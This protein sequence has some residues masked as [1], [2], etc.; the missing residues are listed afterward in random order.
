M[1]EDTGLQLINRAIFTLKARHLTLVEESI[2][3]GTWQGK[4][5]AQMAAQCQY[6]L[7]YLMRDIGPKFWKLLSEAFGEEVAKTNLRVVLERRYLNGTEPLRTTPQVKE[8]KAEIAVRPTQIRIQGGKGTKTQPSKDWGS[9]SEVSVVYGRT[10]ELSKLKQWT[11]TDGCRLIMVRGMSGT[12]KTALLRKLV[13]DIEDEYDHII[14]RNLSYS[15]TP[16]ELVNDLLE[17]LYY[18]VYRYKRDRLSQLI[19]YLRSLRCLLILDGAETIMA[20]GQLAGRYRR[21]YTDYGELLRRL[22]EES[23]KSCV[24]ISS[25]ENIREVDWKTAENGL[26][27]SLMLSGLKETEARELFAEVGLI[28]E[29]NLSALS[30]RYQGNPAALK[31]VAKLIQEVFNSNVAEFLERNIFVFGDIEELVASSFHRLSVLEKEVS[32]CLAIWGDSVSLDTLEK[33]ITFPMSTKKLL[34]VLVSLRG[35]SLLETHTE[36][37]LSRFALKPMMCEYITKQLVENICGT[38]AIEEAQR[39]QWNKTEDE[40]IELTLSTTRGPVNLSQWLQN[41]FELGWEPLSLLYDTKPDC[42]ALMLRRTFHLRSQQ[43]KK[44][45]KQIR[46]ET[47]NQEREL[48]LLVATRKADPEANAFVQTKQK[49]RIRVQLQPAGE[50]T[51]LPAN[52]KLS[53]LNQSKKTLLSV[54]SVPTENFIQLPLF[55]GLFQERFSIQI[56]LD[57]AKLVEDFVI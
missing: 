5:Y 11:S 1:N 22:G 3:R 36:N 45:F 32:Y 17:S 43:L 50:E 41:K 4:T 7:N 52:I 2:F 49:F 47:S 8:T 40:S 30:H 16:Q 27:R 25:Q 6:S 12:G 34:E 14:W 57:G 19:D 13:E 18:P 38:K 31:I 39:R 15:P 35:R 42:L 24:L 23:H 21:G 10:E 28:E 48:V 46:L 53:L 26:I 55:S 51:T 54:K 56:E 33:S 20:K 29:E 37:G 44:R 9:S